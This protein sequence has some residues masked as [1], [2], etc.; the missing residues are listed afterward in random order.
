M[1]T[2]LLITLASW[3]LVAAV[4]VPVVTPALAHI[5]AAFAQLQPPGN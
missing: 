1:K 3:A 5:D 2:I 4:T